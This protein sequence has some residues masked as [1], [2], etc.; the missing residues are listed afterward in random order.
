MVESE[1]R[2]PPYISNG[3]GDVMTELNAA[4]ARLYKFIKHEGIE[5]YT[6]GLKVTDNK[7]KILLRKC[8]SKNSNVMTAD[9]N[10]AMFKRFE[11]IATALEADIRLMR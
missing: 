4:T 8:A 11:T 5:I 1:Y 7:T 6:T 9:D 10:A 2:A 3:N